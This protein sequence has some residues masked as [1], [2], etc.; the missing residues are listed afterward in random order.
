MFKYLVGLIN[1]IKQVYGY[2][3]V[4]VINGGLLWVKKEGVKFEIGL[5]VVFK[6]GYIGI[7]DCGNV[8]INMI[9][10]VF[11]GDDLLDFCFLVRCCCWYNI[12]WYCLVQY[13]RLMIYVEFDD[14]L[15]FVGWCLVFDYDVFFI[16]VRLK[17]LY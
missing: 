17:L 11:I 15:Q 2:E 16:D 1:I 13:S 5:F 4:F 10:F 3:K 14:V 8:Q 6:V 12:L 7:K 9:V